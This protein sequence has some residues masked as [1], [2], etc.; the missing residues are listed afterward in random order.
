M[1]FTSTDLSSIETAIR[2]IITRL[3]TGSKEIVRFSIGDKSWDYTPSKESLE[4][5]QELK[6]LVLDDV[7]TSDVKPRFFLTSTEKGLS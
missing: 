4:T 5:L 3:A 6:K 2:A 7:Q 1:A